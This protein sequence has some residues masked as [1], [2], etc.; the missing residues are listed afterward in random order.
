MIYTIILVPYRVSFVE[1]DSEAWQ[2]FELGIDL[3]F[4]LDVLINCVSAQVIEEG[5]ITNIQEILSNYM[6]TWMVF[7][8]LSAIPFSFILHNTRWSTMTKLAKLP[9]LYRGFKIAKIIQGSN[10]VEKLYSIKIFRCIFDISLRGKRILYFFIIFSIVCHLLT[11]IWY[12]ISQLNTSRNWVIK[13]NYLDRSESEMYIAS[14]YWVIT[15]LA[16][17]GYGDITPDNSIE[18][19]FC[20]CVML[21]GVFFYSYT[22]GIITSI[23]SEIDRLRQRIDNKMIILQEITRNYNIDKEL[24]KRIRKNLKL[25]T[26]STNREYSDLLK[27]LP[28]R[29]A[30]QLNFIINK[31]LVE[32][33]NKFFEKKPLAFISQI[34]EVLRSVKLP[35]KEIIFLKGFISS[36]IYFI[37]KGHVCIYDM[38]NR[39]EVSSSN[40]FETEYFGDI[41][42]L[43]GESRAVSAKTMKYSELLILTKEG[44]MDALRG[45]DDLKEEMMKEAKRK[46]TSFALN[47]ERFSR[48]FQLNRELVSALPDDCRD[49]QTYDEIDIG[50][51]QIDAQNESIDKANEI[52]RLRSE[53]KLI[54]I[55]DTL[56]KKTLRL[57]DLGVSI[58]V[59]QDKVRVLEDEIL[60]FI[61]KYQL[62]C[63]L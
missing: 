13:L 29:M 47:Y 41:G 22:V 58:N 15:T 63:D 28:R 61:N 9:R 19:G 25:N 12:F 16:T 18:R 11:C 21:I 60:N 24:E 4:I 27:S 46:K 8:L 40:L 17:V 5:L 49:P 55:R 2:A 7:D 59:V 34:L 33:G 62:N 14:L 50:E 57:I 44:L 26:S 35:A 39:T 1:S 31:K 52:Q 54:S 20:I 53:R 36:E 42:V 56:S 45:N 3:I 38:Y 43:L 23:M 6:K 30:L 32:K 10:L 37:S 51:D 48:E